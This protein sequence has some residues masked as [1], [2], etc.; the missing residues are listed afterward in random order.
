Y[1]HETPARVAGRRTDRHRHSRWFR[2]AGATLQVAVR[3]RPRDHRHALERLGVLRAQEPQGAE[4]SK[5]PEKTKLVRKLAC[6]V[7][8]R[9]SAE[10]AL[11]QEFNTLH[12]QREACDA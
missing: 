5:P 9:K 1:R 12:A 8:T 2:M 6:A 3:H 11:E 4:M 7:Y 10:E